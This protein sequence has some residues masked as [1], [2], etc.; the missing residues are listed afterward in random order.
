MHRCDRRVPL[1]AARH[2]RKRMADFVAR[3]RDNRIYDHRQPN[4]YADDH[5]PMIHND[6]PHRIGKRHQ[7]TTF[8]EKRRHPANVM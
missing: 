3:R 5:R 8:L 7:A 2:T 6:N 1:M 4:R